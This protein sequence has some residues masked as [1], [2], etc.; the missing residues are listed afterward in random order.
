M[1]AWRA[2]REV[3]LVPSAHRKGR[4]DESKL[5]DFVAREFRG[6]E[7]FK[8]VDSVSGQQHLMND[9]LV[10]GVLGIRSHLHPA[11]VRGHQDDFLFDEP[12]SRC[13]ADSR[14]AAVEE[15]VI[16]LPMASPAGMDDERV[17]FAKTD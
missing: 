9:S 6:V 5:I 14:R 15:G 3:D 2:S 16:G 8:N 11:G 4:E 10:S 1:S 17:P 13:Q 7:V 12:S